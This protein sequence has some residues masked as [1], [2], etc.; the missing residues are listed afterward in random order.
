MVL[1]ISAP[2]D[3]MNARLFGSLSG[4][5][6]TSRMGENGVKRGCRRRGV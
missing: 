5:R 2:E 3:G 1:F 4:H 6:A